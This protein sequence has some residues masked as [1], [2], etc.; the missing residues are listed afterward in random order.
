M[1]KGIE[2]YIIKSKTISMNPPKSDC[3][4]LALASVPLNKNYIFYKL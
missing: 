4:F 1:H 3:E 2:Q